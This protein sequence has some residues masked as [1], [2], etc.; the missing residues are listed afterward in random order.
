MRESKKYGQPLITDIGAA[1]VQGWKWEPA[2]E[3]SILP[4]KFTKPGLRIECYIDL[5]SYYGPYNPEIRQCDLIKSPRKTPHFTLL[6]EI[7]NEQFKTVCTSIYFR[8]CLALAPE[9]KLPQPRTFTEAKPIV[10][11][12]STTIRFRVNFA[13][14]VAGLVGIGS[15]GTVCGPENPAIKPWYDVRMKNWGGS[16]CPRKMR[17][18][19][20]GDVYYELS[21]DYN[22]WGGKSRTHEVGAPGRVIETTKPNLTTVHRDAIRVLLG[23]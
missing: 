22:R 3:N 17:I 14:H 9:F 10:W 15:D 23:K 7:A 5:R 13:A 12:D 20:D 18:A 2:G 8:K 1:E 21:M 6:R 19:T 11:Q 4:A 16:Y